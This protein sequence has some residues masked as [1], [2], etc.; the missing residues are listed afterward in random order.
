MAPD[1]FAIHPVE[2]GQEEED[3]LLLDYALIST[4]A[5]STMNVPTYAQWVE[6][7]DNRPA[8]EY[9]ATLLRILSF[10]TGPSRWILKSPHHLEFLD[11]FLDVFED[12]TVVWA[13]RDPCETLPSFCSMMCHGRGIFS[14]AVDPVAIGDQW[15]RKTARMVQRG[16]AV[17]RAR[18]DRRFVDVEYGELMRDPL[19]SLSRIYDAAGLPFT[20]AVQDRFLL[21]LGENRQ[22]RYGIHRY[23]M[24]S[25]GLTA[26]R[27][28]G[29][30]GDY[31]R[32]FGRK[33]DE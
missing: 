1:F 25:F 17:R 10:F 31:S 22:H 5:E 33:D 2:A 26:K 11:V 23:D 29:A 19:L 6:T 30:Y 24:A 18:A 27:I 7:H 14:D 20:E 3:V 28:H 12:A 16:M 21:T 13:H 9:M 8:Y 32:R 15:L 4:V